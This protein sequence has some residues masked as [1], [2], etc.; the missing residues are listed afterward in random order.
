LRRWLTC[1]AATTCLS[2]ALLPAASQTLAAS[3]PGEAAKTLVAARRLTESQY[4]NAIADIFGADVQVNGRFEAGRREG[5]LLEVGNQELSV[6]AGGFVQYEAMARSVADQVLAE[7]RR[8]TS[9]PCQP[10]DAK[11]ADSACAS[12]FVQA[13][14]DL[15]FRRP[16]AKREVAARVALADQGASAARDFYAGLKPALVSLLM[17]PEFL[18]RVEAAEPDPS[19]KGQLRLD[20]Y[21]KAARLSYLLWDAEPDPILLEAAGRGELHTPEGL[22]RQ[23]TRMLASPRVEKGVRAFFTDML[24]MDQ[25]DGL[26]KDV[27]AYPKFSQSL[28]DSA[29]EETLRVLVDHLLSQDGDYRDIFLTRDTLMNR[30]LAAVY[31]VPFVAGGQEWTRYSFPKEA[32]RAGVLTGVTFLSMFSHPAASSPTK[33]GVKVNEIFRCSPTPEPPAD[34]D[35][36]K[37]QAVDRGT[38][39]TR[40]IAHMTNPGCSAC[41]KA[42]DPLGLAL[43]HFDGIGQRRT[44]ENGA[45]IDVSAELRGK[46]ISGAPGV[47]QLLRDDPKVPA[48]LVKQ[49]Y[50]YGV[51]RTPGDDDETFLAAQAKTFAADGYRLKA[52]LR[53]IGSS[54]EF[55]KVAPPERAVAP[56]PA[57]KVAAIIPARTAGG[58]R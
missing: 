54:P 48:C 11:A 23:L 55:F 29:R 2:A 8:E 21:S 20:A 12:K 28:V 13:Y 31:N 18:F 9:V 1:L 47:G 16:L 24:Q 49:V 46:L 44:L 6:T 37:V 30:H 35:F 43:E 52:L 25:L 36:S 40:L 38:V 27:A 34:V 7:K 15:L 42:S 33:R 58:P 4:R 26:T 17:A 39:R 45:L 56:P 10:A 50:A 51:G 32:E 14:G 41:H 53:R 19:H 57:Q 5:G 22:D 3:K